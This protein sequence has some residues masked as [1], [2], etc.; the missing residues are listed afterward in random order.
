MADMNSS[1]EVDD[2]TESAA[3][4]PLRAEAKYFIIKSLK[5]SL[6]EGWTSGCIS[7]LL[8][9]LEGPECR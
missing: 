1:K 2:Q 8:E 3:Y 4:E 7:E 9:L 6:P 5:L